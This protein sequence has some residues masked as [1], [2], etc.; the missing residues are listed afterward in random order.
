[1]TEFDP[2]LLDLLRHHVPSGSVVSTLSNGKPN[3]ITEVTAAGVSVDTERSR[4]LGTGSQLVPAWMLQTAWE[5]LTKR[6]VVTN[7]ELLHQHNIKRSSAVCA[8]LARLP[9][10][11]VASARPITLRYEPPAK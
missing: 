9:G 7:R 11:V 1:M 3:H 8:I 10:V 4:A 5:Y 2:T 6:G